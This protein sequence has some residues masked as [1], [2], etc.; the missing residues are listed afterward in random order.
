MLDGRWTE[1]GSLSPAF[2][3]V[4]E[5]WAASSQAIGEL[6]LHQGLVVFDIQTSNPVEA[7]LNVDKSLS[8]E[9]AKA[10]VQRTGKTIHS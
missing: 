4:S 3:V 6:S 10:L 5:T 9:V 8:G 7:W 2:N 1:G